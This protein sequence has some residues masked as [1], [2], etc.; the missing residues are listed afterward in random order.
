MS[1]DLGQTIAELRS[2][3]VADRLRVVQAVWDSLPDDAPA[4]MSSEQR[5]EVNRRLDAH[6][7]APDD[8][9]TW[10]QVTGVIGSR[11]KT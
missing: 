10:D 9:L 6:E 5:A 4:S 2:L 11:A 7:A 1:I 8:L 3:S